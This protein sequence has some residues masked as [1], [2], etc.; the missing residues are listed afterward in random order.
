M[1]SSIG[2]SWLSMLK[3]E[4]GGTASIRA[5]IL[6]EVEKLYGQLYTSVN[7]PFC[8]S[9]EDPRAELTRHSFSTSASTRSVWLWDSLKTIRH[10]ARTV[11]RQSF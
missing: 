1:A 2:Q 7:Q 11:L 3:I 5:E 4:D 6:T 9:T 10:W 8:S